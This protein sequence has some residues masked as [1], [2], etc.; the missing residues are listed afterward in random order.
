MPASRP[1]EESSY[2]QYP[3]EENVLTDDE[4]I[5]VEELQNVFLKIKVELAKVIVGQ[6]EAIEKLFFMPSIKRTWFAY[7]SSRFGQDPVSEFIGKYEFTD[8][9]TDTIYPRLNA[10]RCHGNR[11]PSK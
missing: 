2:D 6:E 1:K 10:F 4:V 11:N 3:S 5:Q 7:G 8:F 9:W